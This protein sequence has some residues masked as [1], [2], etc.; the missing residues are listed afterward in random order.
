M[1]IFLFCFTCNE[2]TFECLKEWAINVI[3]PEGIQ[4]GDLREFDLT[5]NCPQ[6]P[7]F[8]INK[9][10]IQYTVCLIRSENTFQLNIW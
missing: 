3:P 8:K 7:S 2:D 1:H 4:T 5:H 10:Y 6:V 9:L